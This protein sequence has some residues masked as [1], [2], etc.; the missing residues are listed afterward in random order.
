MNL[1]S[2]KIFLY[3]ILGIAALALFFSFGSAQTGMNEWADK[4]FNLAMWISLL[5][6]AFMFFKRFK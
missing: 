1:P 4:F 6:I 5:F 2:V 3:G